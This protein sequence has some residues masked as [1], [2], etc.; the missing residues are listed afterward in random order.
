MCEDSNSYV[1]D[2]HI[3]QD[4]SEVGVPSIKD[5][6]LVQNFYQKCKSR[7]IYPLLIHKWD[8]GLILDPI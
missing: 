1:V 8:F 7:N 4:N 3:S 6:P 2:L 5:S